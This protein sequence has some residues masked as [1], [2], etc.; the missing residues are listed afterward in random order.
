MCVCVGGGRTGEWVRGRALHMDVWH[1]RASKGRRLGAQQRKSKSTGGADHSERHHMLG[2][3]AEMDAEPE[4]GIVP[5]AASHTAQHRRSSS[6]A[7]AAPTHFRSKATLGRGQS[8][9]LKQ[10][11]PMKGGCVVAAQHMR[12]G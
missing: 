1:E 7:S 4:R 8:R 2:C 6:T 10:R 9:K 11:A 3:T 5:G 12:R